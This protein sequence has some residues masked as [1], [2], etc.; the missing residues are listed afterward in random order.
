MLKFKEVVNLTP[1]PI[2]VFVGDRQTTIPPSGKVLRA[3]END[4]EPF[5]F[6]VEG[7]GC[8]E[9]VERKLELNQTLVK[10]FAENPDIL[11]IVS[12][13]LLELLRQHDANLFNVAAP[14]TG[15]R[16]VRDSEGRIIGTK[17]FVFLKRPL[18]HSKGIK[19]LQ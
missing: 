13:P 18:L 12:L 6:E 16:V 3:E 19:G 10:I 17:G 9:G 14:D 11:F 2:T 5:I 7:M 8:F 4:S 1:H 15:K